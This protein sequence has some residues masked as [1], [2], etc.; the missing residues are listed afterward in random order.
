MSL[1][2][3]FDPVDLSARAGGSTQ[4][5]SPEAQAAKDAA[6]QMNH[7]LWSYLYIV[8]GAICLAVIC[9][10][11]IDITT[12]YIRTI[13]CLNND[14]QRYFAIPSPNLARLKEHVLYA[15]VF[16]KRHNREIQLSSAINVGTL[17]T[18]FQ[19]LFLI[20]YFATNVAF[21][22]I[23]IPFAGD[24]KTA[25][26]TLRNR[27]GVMATIN[28]VCSLQS[29]LCSQPRPKTNKIQL[30]N[31]CPCSYSQGETTH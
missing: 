21:C 11:I 25:T 3:A 30:I 14:R 2:G 8:C 23:E 6:I 28:M 19:L 7:D 24:Y 27:S 13:V 20:A 5:L 26:T 1:S 9:W 15:P 18:R 4:P 17:P 22:V 10:K 29:F 16:R 31:R 12:K